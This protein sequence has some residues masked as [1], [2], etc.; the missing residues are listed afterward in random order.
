MPKGRFLSI[1]WSKGLCFQKWGI[2]PS[3]WKIDKA[4]VFGLQYPIFSISR[5]YFLTVESWDM[6]WRLLHRTATSQSTMFSS[7][8][9][10]SNFNHRLM[11]WRCER[12]WFCWFRTTFAHQGAWTQSPAWTQSVKV[13]K[14]QGQ[15]QAWVGMGGWPRQ[16]PTQLLKVFQCFQVEM[17]QNIRSILSTAFGQPEKSKHFRTVLSKNYSRCWHFT[18]HK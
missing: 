6:K 16:S 7:G 12:L 4:S 13:W 15:R 14:L 18:F 9:Q 17:G 8:L 2:P 1:Q 3:G 5:S 11:S 10:S